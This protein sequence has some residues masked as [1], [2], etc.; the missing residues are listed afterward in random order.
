M[1][2]FFYEKYA[3]KQRI[4]QLA[5]DPHEKE[6]ADALQASNNPK[7]YQRDFAFVAQCSR[8][9]SIKPQNGGSFLFGFVFLAN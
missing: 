2:F 6:R 5:A 7:R 9:E 3:G 1:G 8:R 4:E